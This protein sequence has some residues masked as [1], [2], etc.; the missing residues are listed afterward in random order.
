MQTDN[1]D[2]RG[3]EKALVV[4]GRRRLRAAA[5]RPRGASLWGQ[6]GAGLLG[7]VA[8]NAAHELGRRFLRNPPR[9]DRV[10]EAGLAAVFKAVGR[11]P[12]RGQALYVSTLGAD[13]F[14]NGLY[15]GALLAGRGR[16]PMWR[17]VLGGAVAG[18]GAAWLPQRMGLPKP[19][20]RVDSRSTALTVGWYVLGGLAA[21]ATSRWLRRNVAVSRR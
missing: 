19:A 2:A 18:A 10:G 3:P 4:R 1:G 8:L 7:A 14:A 13:L 11:K 17:G 15:Y 20:R 6:A 9:I 21:A 16:Y 12:P 5:H